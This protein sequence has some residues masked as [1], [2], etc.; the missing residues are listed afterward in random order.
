MQVA[1]WHMTFIALAILNGIT[2]LF[3]ILL[4]ETLPEA[5]RI[6]VG[7]IRS[8]LGLFKVIK[9]PLFTSILLVGGIMT[10]PFMA[11]IA[12]ASYVYVNGFHTSET[13]F[14][15]YF[16]LTS[17]FSVIGP[18]LYG[19]F[20]QKPFKK[21][22]WI[23]FSVAL[24]AGSLLLSIGKI[25]PILFLLSYL[26]FTV[27]SSYLRPNI[28]NILLNAQKENIGA[29]SS[30]MNFGFTILGSIGM[31]IGSLRWSDY[32]SGIAITIFLFSISAML[33]FMAANKLDIFN[34]IEAGK[35]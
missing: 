22:F 18:L 15:I 11:Y 34:R 4:E 10:A 30:A 12:V 32:I 13:M 6:Q 24:L 29:A 14:S 19:R 31:F 28:A 2:L 20:G 27:M 9:N 17:A 23:S 33:I 26:P 7:T 8:I 35:E 21:V 3:V 5:K 16:A 25:N 1:D